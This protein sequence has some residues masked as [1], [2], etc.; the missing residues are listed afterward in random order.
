MGLGMLYKKE[1]LVI[2]AKKQFE[3][4]ISIDPDHKVAQREMNRLGEKKK[5]NLK[6]FFT[7]EPFGKKR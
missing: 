5:K 7:F 6:D 2:K 1:G 3:K 4:A